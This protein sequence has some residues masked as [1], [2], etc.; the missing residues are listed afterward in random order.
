MKISFNLNYHTQWGESLYICG[1]IFQLGNGDAKAALEMKLSSPDM[2]V[3]ELDMDDCPH[4]FNY[5][6][7]VKSQD[8]PWRF[9]WGEPHRFEGNPELC[10]VKIF[11]AWQDQPS[12]KPYYSS[13]F[14][15]GILMRK[16]RDSSLESLPGTLQ[17]RVSAPMVLPDEVLAMTGE[18]EFFGNWD[19]SQA[20]I[21][22]DAFY[23]EW[24]INLPLSEI[25]EPF[26]YKFLILKKE[27][28]EVVA[29]E[30]MDNRI[31]GFI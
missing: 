9:E 26:Q 30:E 12:D 22:N 7:I 29:W 16:S 4:S 2:W 23:P 19:P 27:T 20:L 14:V 15:D 6:F 10:V 11:D 21:L 28:K 24:R 18:G 13:A 8:K 31:C 25:N 17:F 5:F 1:D 3:A